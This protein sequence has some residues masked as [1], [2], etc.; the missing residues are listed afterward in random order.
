VRVEGFK[1]E[2]SEKEN[3]QDPNEVVKPPELIKEAQKRQPATL[4]RLI[5]MSMQRIARSL[6][7]SFM[8][9]TSGFLKWLSCTIHGAR[10][11]GPR[12]IVD[13]HVAVIIYTWLSDKHML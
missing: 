4:I 8:S 5:K 12:F 1:K 2:G 9:C 6:N 13:I 10:K 3:G 11:S 7:W